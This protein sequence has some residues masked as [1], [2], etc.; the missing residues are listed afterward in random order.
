MPINNLKLKIN[1]N[2]LKILSNISF[3]FQVFKIILNY[4]F[5]IYEQ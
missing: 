5:I 2:V 1:Q 4:Y 3:F